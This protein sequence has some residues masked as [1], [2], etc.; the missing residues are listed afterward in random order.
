M[1]VPAAELSL[2]DWQ[3]RTAERHRAQIRKFLD[4]SE[5]AVADAERLT[6]WLA[7]QVCERERRAD[8]VRE[9]L[10]TQLRE[11]RL[12]WPTRLRLS[13]MIG[14]ALSRSETTLTTKIASRIRAEA[15]ERMLTLIARRTAPWRRTPAAT[16]PRRAPRLRRR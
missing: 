2:F 5:C 14:S 3:G 4:L 15:I 9:A 10:L 16:T 7:T 8:R 6:H 1:K 12:E 13:Q 11:E